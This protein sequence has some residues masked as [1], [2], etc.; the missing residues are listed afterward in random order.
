MKLKQWFV[1][2][3]PLGRFGVFLSSA[4]HLRN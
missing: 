2:V 4:V 3:V 1:L